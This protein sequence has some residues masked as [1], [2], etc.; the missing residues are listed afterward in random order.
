MDP[1]V[2]WIIALALLV[3]ALAAVANMVN[4]SR[5]GGAC[6]GYLDK[7]LAPPP[8]SPFD[9]MV[10][11]DADTMHRI[12]DMLNDPAPAEANARA[13]EFEA[14]KYGASRLGPEAVEVA[15]RVG[16]GGGRAA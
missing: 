13:T 16:P 11:Y 10:P 2:Q 12:S 1:I 15:G 3:W 5:I 9:T 6:R 14:H 4:M 7:A 8:P